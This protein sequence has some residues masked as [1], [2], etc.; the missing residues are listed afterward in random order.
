M[1]LWDVLWGAALPR[2]EVFI[3]DTGMEFIMA[4]VFRCGHNFIDDA[5]WL[6]VLRVMVKELQNQTHIGLFGLMFC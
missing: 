3:S 2:L 5:S 6:W 1:S 4:R